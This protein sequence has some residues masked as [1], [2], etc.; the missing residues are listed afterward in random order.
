MPSAAPLKTN[1]T[2]VG[3]QSLPEPDEPEFD[4]GA[5]YVL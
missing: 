5:F 2:G 4:A 1:E 3:Q